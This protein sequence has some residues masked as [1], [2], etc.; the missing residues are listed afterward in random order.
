MFLERPWTG[1]G[2]VNNQFE[3]ADRIAEQ[4]RLKRDSHNLVL[5]VLTTT[6]IVGA[7]PFFMALALIVRAAWRARHGLHGI[8]PIALLVLAGAGAMSGNPI[9][10]TL[11]W[12]TMAYA[13][14]AAVPLVRQ[15]RAPLRSTSTLPLPLASA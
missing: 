9:T 4:D 11:F 12:L 8:T 7:V 10:N 15:A 5:E 3:L 1:W 6:G 2:S 14:A 13:V